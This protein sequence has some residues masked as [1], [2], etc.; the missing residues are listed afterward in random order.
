MD[1][2]FNAEDIPALL[3]GFSYLLPEEGELWENLLN[4]A[5]KNFEKIDGWKL[6]MMIEAAA[7]VDRGSV[8]NW[9]SMMVHALNSFP[10]MKGEHVGRILV[11]F[12][13]A[14]LATESAYRDMLNI[15]IKNAPHYNANG[16]AKLFYGFVKSG[17]YEGEVLSNLL[18]KI[19]SGKIGL[20]S[21][22]SFGLL[23]SAIE[24]TEPEKA[25]WDKLSNLA[26]EHRKKWSN[27][28]KK[29]FWKLVKDSKNLEAG[30]KKAFEEEKL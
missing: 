6:A 7:R 3:E 1:K 11:A 27:R 9:K 22:E 5:T 15:A 14:D 2:D 21:G 19:F 18:N 12:V 25:G 20:L 30:V 28:D 29:A 13:K 24:Q 17:E 23:W 16:H 4:L 8:K 26:D 10:H